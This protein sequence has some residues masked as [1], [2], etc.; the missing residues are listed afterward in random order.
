MEKEIKI[1]IIRSRSLPNL[2]LS[3]L[4]PFYSINSMH[5][6]ELIKVFFLIMFYT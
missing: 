6:K 3:T 4:N 5:N 2:F 1:T